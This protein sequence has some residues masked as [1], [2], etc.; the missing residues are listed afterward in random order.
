MKKLLIRKLTLSSVGFLMACICILL[1][2]MPVSA[3]S[4][5]DTGDGGTNLKE[6]KFSKADDP[7]PFV[8]YIYVEGDENNPYNNENRDV[9]FYLGGE[10][11]LYKTE[12]HHNY[13]KSEIFQKFHVVRITGSAPKNVKTPYHVMASCSDEHAGNYSSK[14]AFFNQAIDTSTDISLNTKYNEFFIVCGSSDWIEQ[15]GMSKLTQLYSL[16]HSDKQDIN[17]NKAF[18][19]AVNEDVFA[20]WVEQMN[21][22]PTITGF[23]DSNG[24]V[25]SRDDLR[26]MGYDVLNSDAEEQEGGTN[27]G[28]TAGSGITGSDTESGTDSSSTG[29]SSS[30]QQKTSEKKPISA[31]NKETTE[32]P[33]TTLLV[34]AA[35][36]VIAVVIFCVMKSKKNK[37]NSDLFI[38]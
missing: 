29:D 9:T 27:T 25:Y 33:S 20:Y 31:S 10:L 14:M 4:E 8:A 38:D 30:S 35:V 21:E 34:I 11:G 22:D 1:A 24:N 5:G 13:Y 15:N 36:I 12:A 26:A 18:N 37:N 17:E 7:Q 28:D 3:A 2:W 6:A 19:S 23:T 16:F 32:G